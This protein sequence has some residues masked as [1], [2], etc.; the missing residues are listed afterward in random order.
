[1]SKHFVVDFAG[2]VVAGVLT[3][4]FVVPALAGLYPTITSTRIT[5]FS[6]RYIVAGRAFDD[7]NLLEK[8]TTAMQAR[9]VTLLAC[10][11]SVTRSL[12]AAVERFRHVPVQMLVLDADTPECSSTTPF[13]IPVRQRDGQRPYGIDDEAVERYW[14]DIMP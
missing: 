14:R 10:G 9:A 13:A 8:H 11:P 3:L 5:V 2:R 12:K 6:D 4:S 7:L 1:M